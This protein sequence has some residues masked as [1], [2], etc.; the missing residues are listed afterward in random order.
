MTQE[1]LGIVWLCGC[2]ELE[3]RECAALLRAA[4]SPARL[5]EEYEK[6]A[7]TVINSPKARL[8]KERDA[9]FAAASQLVKR[10]EREGCFALT[11]LDDDYPKRSKTSPLRP[12]CYTGRATVL[13]L[14]SVNSA[15]SARA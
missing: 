8:Y 14:P 6:I 9:R 7:P 4:A 12:F 3:K 5:L 10:L 1:E 11:V 2:T 13:F 15:S